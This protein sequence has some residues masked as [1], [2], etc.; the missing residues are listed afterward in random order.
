MFKKRNQRV[1]IKSRKTRNNLKDY[2]RKKK[3]EES[4]NNNYKTCI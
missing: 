4:Y 3:K 2:S 1:A